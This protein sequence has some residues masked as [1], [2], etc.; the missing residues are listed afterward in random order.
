MQELLPG[1]NHP[2]GTG[3]VVV[4]VSGD[5]DDEFAARLQSGVVLLGADGQIGDPDDLVS[6]E[7]PR[8]RDGSVETSPAQSLQSV[9]GLPTRMARRSLSGMPS[10]VALR[11]RSP[12]R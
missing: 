9:R 2:V 10:W 11:V 3:Q 8:S 4:G 6:A 1:Q 12:S 7:Q 5:P